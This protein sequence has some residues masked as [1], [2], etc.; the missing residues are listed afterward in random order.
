M[1]KDE[2]RQKN[3]NGINRADMIFAMAKEYALNLKRGNYTRA[4]RKDR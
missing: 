1:R 2:L 3:V 4:K